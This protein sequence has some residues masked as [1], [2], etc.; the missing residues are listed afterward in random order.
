MPGSAMSVAGPNIIINTIVADSLSQFADELEGAEDFNS[1]LNSLIK[2]TIRKHR[3]IIFNGDGYSKEWI[4]EAKE[5]GLLNLATAADALPHYSDE[6]NLALFLRHRI[7]TEKEVY[8]RQEILTRSY[9]NITVIEAATMCDMAEKD[10]L[11][12]INSYISKLTDSIGSIKASGVPVP[13]YSVKTAEKLSALADEMYDALC[14]LSTNVAK[15]N[16]VGASEACAFYCRDSII[17][18]MERLRRAA[19]EAELVTERSF[20][21]FPTYGDLLYHP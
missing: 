9:C 15:A 10:I 2:K 4:E 7:F 21:P 11:P 16:C 12:A 19:D 5:R 1:A 20:W 14:I 17:P 18:V 6:K 13:V 3:R 8:S